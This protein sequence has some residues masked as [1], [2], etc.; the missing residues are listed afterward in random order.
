MK[1]F[2]VKLLKAR[3]SNQNIKR[4]GSQRRKDLSGSY[5]EHQLSVEELK[6][7][8]ADSY[9]DADQPEC[10][11]GLGQHEAKKRLHDGGPNL[12][13]K[14]KQQSRWNFLLNQHFYKF[15]LLLFGA[16]ILS[17]MAY[18]ISELDHKSDSALT[19]LTACILIPA[20][21]LMSFISF[22]QERKTMEVVHTTED[23]V[24]QYCFVIRDCETKCIPTEELVVG[25]L[26]HVSSGQRIPADVRILQGNGLRIDLSLITGNTSPV[27]YT[28]ET[29]AKHVSVFNAYN[30]A[31]Q[32]TYVTDGD[33]IGLVI[34]IGR[35]TFL[36]NM[37]DMY[38]QHGTT[39]LM[40]QDIKRAVD[41]ISLIALFMAIAFFIVG[42]IV[43]GFNNILYY[44]VVGFLVIV[45]ANVPQGLPPAMMS[46][47]AII[48]KRLAKKHIYIRNLDYYLNN[49]CFLVPLTKA[50]IKEMRKKMKLEPKSSTMEMIHAVMGICNRVS[51][52]RERPSFSVR[53]A[54]AASL[55]A[56]T[57]ERQ[58]S[59]Q[60]TKLFTVVH[61]KTGKEVIQEPKPEFARAVRFQDDVVN[62][63]ELDFEDVEKAQ[64]YEDNSIEM[65]Q[66]S[67]T[68]SADAA[69][70]SYLK[71][72]NF[73]ISSL[74]QKYKPIYEIPFNSIRRWQLLVARCEDKIDC[75][76][77]PHDGV[78]EDQRVHVVMI[79]GAPE[80]V[81]ERCNQYM[82]NDVINDI[83]PVF[84]RDFNLTLET[85]SKHGGRVIAFA[86]KFF[87]THKDGKISAV[88]DTF[89]QHN[90][91]FLGMS[92]LIDPPRPESSAAIKMC[93]EAGLKLHMITG[94]HPMSAM[95]LACRIGLINQKIENIKMN[96]DRDFDSKHGSNWAVVHGRTI[97]G[98]T[99][100]DWNTLL[101][102]PYLVFARTTPEQSLQIVEALQR[103]NEIVALTGG[104]VNDA[105]AI[106]QAN[107]GISTKSFST[108]IARK[109]ADIM[110]DNNTFAAITHGVAE[111]RILF[112]N[113]QLSIAYTLAHLWPEVCPI[114]ANFTLGLPLG[115][116][117]LQILS[118]DLACE[119]PP[120]ISLAY[121]KPERDIMK[122]PP[123]P[124]K[125]TL[126]SAAL[127]IYSYL[128]IG[129]I[130]T[131]GCFASYFTVYYSH[132]MPPGNLFFS[133]S[134][135][136]HGEA[137]NLTTPLSDRIMT[138][139]QQMEVRGQ[140]AAAYQITL[141]V[142]QVF[143]I[144]MC[145]TRRVSLFRHGLTSYAVF[146]A[147]F[148]EVSILCLLIYTPALRTLLGISVPPPFV[149]LFGPVVGV[150]LLVFTE[151]RKYFIRHAEKNAWYKRFEF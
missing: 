79:K 85:F 105:P 120:A 148:I 145:T 42:C 132:G 6:D 69:I 133:H 15:W 87:V 109:A 75:A 56:A 59:M 100:D 82:K 95:A 72:V 20:I 64:Y 106:S 28:H 9:I 80:V 144:F 81:I 22:W 46:H 118:I 55:A 21:L 31:F 29:A 43:N 112:E 130:I 140:A 98:M 89:P 14:P 93:K 36:G 74:G 146:V 34:R 73:S 125:Q 143:H 1:A 121:E 57:R 103:R 23:V 61:P 111:G 58:S 138:A 3:K 16:S 110:L 137:E 99:L 141:V 90:L 149:W 126:V 54:R 134:D 52:W 48:A 11:D 26:L 113:M 70:Y 108:D 51:K 50:E 19:P 116:S 8:Y 96:F 151:L 107:I 32:G 135:F 147:V 40:R 47:L 25:D 10:S 115:L 39:S 122:C 65:K 117:P 60:R 77:Y 83:G 66:I 18:I 114:I 13:E 37:S 142:A 33:G 124:Q 4:L 76:L 123:R 68:E 119:L 7:I 131:I 67:A 30:T 102:K 5:V 136:W 86:V 139:D 97:D 35:F 45:V 44:F 27:E 104:C 63:R 62:V 84:E 101:E 94:D 71:K 129:T 150:V 127:M 78:T 88:Q 38:L 53:R 49:E 128:C 2:L 92:S 12:V 24:G 41:R 91:V 17:I